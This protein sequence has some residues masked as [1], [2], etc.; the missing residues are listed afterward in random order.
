MKIFKINKNINVVCT[1]EGTRYG[2]R[3]LA[4]LM[5]NN[6]ERGHAKACYYN[7]TWEAFEFQS[8]LRS[9]IEKVNETHLLTDRQKK[10]IIAKINN[11]TI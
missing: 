8:V 4:T 1:S 11:S 5:Y 10:N 7:R 6:Y 2:F 9:V 3:H